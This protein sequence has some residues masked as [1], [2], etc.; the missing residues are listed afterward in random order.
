MNETL[1]VRFHASLL[2][3]LN[4]VLEMRAKDKTFELLAPSETLAL[5]IIGKHKSLAMSE[6]ARLAGTAA[7]TMTGIVDRLVRRH[8]ARRTTSSADRRVVLVELT[9]NGLKLFG[10][11]QQFT[12][13]IIAGL[14]KTLNP[15]EQQSFVE[16]FERIT[17]PL[18]S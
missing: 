10:Q 2:D 5:E 16:M 11:H 3:I 6:L 17:A 13:R 12:K 8:I 1:I 15:E 7:N 18:K 4:G 14:L 9:D